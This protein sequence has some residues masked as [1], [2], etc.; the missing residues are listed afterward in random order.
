MGLFAH[1]TV[2]AR[3][4]LLDLTAFLL[5]LLPAVY[6]DLRSRR[7]PDV[8][9]LASAALLLAARVVRRSLELAHAVGVVVG[10]GTLL[11]LW[12]LMRSRVGLGDLKLSGLVGFFLGP[13]GWALAAFV[14]SAAGVLFLLA[15]QAARR[16]T[17]RDS[18]PFAPFLVGGAVASF[19]LWPTLRDLLGALP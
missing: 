15:R 11:L 6:V 16:G 3:P 7:I 8:F 13:W 12:L 19:V 5:P 2:T 18:V 1:A 17:L 4:R 10:L 9:L 14:A